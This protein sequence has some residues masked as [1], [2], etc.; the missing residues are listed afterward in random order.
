[1]DTF[2]IILLGGLCGL[3]G[4]GAWFRNRRIVRLVVVF[5][6]F[7]ISFSSVILLTTFGPRSAVSQR[8]Q[9]GGTPSMDFAEGVSSAT[10]ISRLYYPYIMLSTVGLTALAVLS[11][12]KGRDDGID[13]SGRSAFKSSPKP[14]E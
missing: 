3:I 4:A 1:M 12:K 11:P 6:L 14:R 9:Q 7:C 5:I 2:D 10:R 8:E 13:K